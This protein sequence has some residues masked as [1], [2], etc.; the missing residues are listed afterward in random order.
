MTLTFQFCPEALPFHTDFRVAGTQCHLSTNSHEILA[1]AA[2]WRT[3]TAHPAAHSFRM[4]ILVDPALDSIADSRAHFRGLRHLVFASLPRNSFVVFD[5]VRRHVRG[6]LSA[7][8]ASNDTFWNTLLLPI[9]VGILGT[10]MGVAPLHCACL[11]RDGDALLVAGVS[12]AGKST[13]AAALAHQGFALV[14]D[15]WTYVS[16]ESQ[17]L[18]A[19]GLSVPIKLLPDTA[20]FFPKLLEFTPEAALNGELAYVMDARNSLGL[21]VRESSRPRW[22]FFLE[23]T[24]APGCQIL[25]SRPEFVRQFFER[26]AEK[27]PTELADAKASR[28]RLIQKLA[29]CP[30]WIIRTGASPRVTAALVG[31]F[32]SEVQ[33]GAA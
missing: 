2:R 3:A 25:P 9:T 4:E 33:D 21:A 20:R 10:T 30:S 22:I 26:S 12:G 31:R 27:L 15:D 14:S 7:H 1:V 23:R 11:D 6:A 24:S 13:L 8:V 28:S 19:Y 18:T 5:L 16:Q 17:R 32:L 29:E